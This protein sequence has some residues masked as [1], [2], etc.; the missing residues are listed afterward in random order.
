[1]I[2]EMEKMNKNVNK[3]IRIR[4]KVDEVRRGNCFQLLRL[5]KIERDNVFKLI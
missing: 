3:Y 1:M 4:I 5:I 2:D